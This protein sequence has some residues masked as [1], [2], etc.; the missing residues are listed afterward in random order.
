MKDWAET[1]AVRGEFVL[2]AQ[3]S[4]AIESAVNDASLFQLAEMLGQNLVRGFG[5][6]AL[7]LAKAELAALEFVEDERLPF[8]SDDAERN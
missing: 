5:D 4:L 3:D 6:A 2:G 7:E 1:L 8:A